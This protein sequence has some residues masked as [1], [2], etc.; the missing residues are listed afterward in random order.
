MK[1]KLGLV[2]AGGRGLRMGGVDKGA[3]LLGDRPLHEWVIER[4]APMC[5]VLAVVAPARPDWLG[6]DG[7][8]A[9]VPDDTIGGEPIGPAGALLAG[10][11]HLRQ[12][13]EAGWMITAAVDAPFFP[14]DLADQLYAGRGEA[15]AAI[16]R[17]DDGLQPTFG[18]WNAACFTPISEA[19]A[20]KRMYALHKLVGQVD[21][22]SVDV[23]GP[24]HQFLNINTPDDMARA[25]SVLR[26]F[27][28]R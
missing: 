23:A 18:L 2:Y 24:P 5:E 9:Y 10:L 8:I 25:R 7:A 28:R 16:A 3:M 26:E 22:A 14:R 17:S 19:I 4:L 21:G 11:K 6:A 15:L 13:D 12:L 1:A 27:G 20:P